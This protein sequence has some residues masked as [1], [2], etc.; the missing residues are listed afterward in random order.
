MVAMRDIRAFVRRTAAEFK[1][2]RIILFGSHAYGAPTEDSD[3]DMRVVFGR[4]G[5][6]I[7][8]AIE[9]RLRFDAPFPLDLLARSEAELRNHYRIENCAVRE[10]VD[11]WNVLYEAGD[12]RMTGAP[13]QGLQR[14][15]DNDRHPGVDGSPIRALSAAR[16]P[17]AGC[18]RLRGP[19]RGGA[20]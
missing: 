11:K 4:A 18:F 5:R 15:V 16:R 1:P 17:R 19:W 7:D 10:V 2:R 6:S 12:A 9:I 14:R 20:R 3:V 8:Q 13:T